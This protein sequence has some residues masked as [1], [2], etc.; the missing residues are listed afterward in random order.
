MHFGSMNVILLYSD[1]R[2]VS[3]TNVAGRLEGG[4][5]K[6][7]NIFIVCREWPKHVGGRYVMKLHS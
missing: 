7:T 4:K 6:N 1:H 5:C 2:N 3:T